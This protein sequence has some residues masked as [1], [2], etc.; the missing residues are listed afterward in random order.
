MLFALLSLLASYNPAFT[1]RVTKM[2]ADDG[3]LWSANRQKVRI[4][5]VQTPDFENA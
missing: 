5:G 4:A 2:P 1:C 3:L